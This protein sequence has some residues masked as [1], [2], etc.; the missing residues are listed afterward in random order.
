MSVEHI[1]KGYVKICVSEEELE[2][3][4]AG[5]SQLKP[6]LQ[7]Q[8]MKGNGTE[9]D[10]NIEYAQALTRRA[11]KA[12]LAPITPHLYITQCLDEKKPQERAQGL[13]AGLELLKGC[14]FMIVGDKYGISE[15]M[16]REI[17]TAKA[18]RIPVINDAG[19][20]VRAKHEKQRAERLAEEYAK[21]YACCFCRGRNLH[22]CNGYSC[23]EPYQRAYDYAMSKVAAGCMVVKIE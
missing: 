9:L 15:G 6:I 1:G 3:S 8:V 4:I 23:K 21:R 7:A 20:L 5:L 11:L 16:Y 18:L 12:G 10:R 17:E 13:A 19:L 22:T 2:D 14:D